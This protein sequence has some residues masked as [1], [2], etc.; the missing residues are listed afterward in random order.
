MAQI[1]LNYFNLRGRG[2]IVRFI[3]HAAGQD[4]VDNRVEFAD[5]P[6]LKPEAP[7]GQ[8]PFVEITEN[9][10]T[11]KI[12]QSMAISRHLARRFGLAGANEVEQTVADM[13]AEQ[14]LDLLNEF[15]KVHFEKDEA[16]K[17][18]LVEKLH[19]ETLG[20]ILGKLDAQ[21]G[22]NNGYLAGKGLTYADVS[23]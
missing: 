5:W 12:G 2:E 23:K 10:N 15:I 4:F 8:L 19:S 7:L 1:K 6:A 20:N 9:G 18:E 21:I 17:K 14:V 13:Y 16:R 3:L 11:L 22:K